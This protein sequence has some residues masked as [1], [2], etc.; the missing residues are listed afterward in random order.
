MTATVA[1]LR[2]INV[3]GR[4]R[5]PMGDLR[6]ALHA[7]GFGGVRTYLQSGNVV[8]DDVPHGVDDVAAAVSGVVSNTFG[9]DVRVVWRTRDEVTAVLA[10]DPLDA[11]EPDPTKLHVVFLDAAP[12]DDRVAA[13]DPKRSPRDRF[14]VVG[15]E[16]H[17]H[18]PDGAGRSTLTLDWFERVL[19]RTATARNRRTV[20]RL[21]ELMDG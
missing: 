9:L 3:G 5:L 19:Q 15:R 8:F 7:A 16:I 10:R 21:R 17:V 18:Y 4:R 11:D 14:V 6:D 13:L 20:A 2:G 12:D 1:L